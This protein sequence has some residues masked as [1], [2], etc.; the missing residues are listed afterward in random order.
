MTKKARLFVFLLF[1]I[2]F[3]LPVMVGAQ[4]LGHDIGQGLPNVCGDRVL[5]DQEECDDGNNVSGD[6]CSSDCRREFCG[7]GEVQEALEEECDDGNVFNGDTCTADCKKT[8]CG[9]G[10]VQNPNGFG[11]AEECDEESATCQS[12]IR[13]EVPQAC[14]NGD[15]EEFLLE[16][17]FSVL[18]P[19]LPTFLI[20]I[21]AYS[22]PVTIDDLDR[23]GCKEIYFLTFDE[24]EEAEIRGYYPSGSEVPGFPVPIG[25]ELSQAYAY[26]AVEMHLTVADT[27]GDSNKEIIATL[28]GASELVIINGVALP[29]R[30][31][32][33]FGNI[34]IVSHEG[35]LITEREVGRR[36]LVSACEFGGGSKDA[37]MYIEGNRELARVNLDKMNARGELIPFNNNYPLDIPVFERD[38]LDPRMSCA[39]IDGDGAKELLA[40]ITY[41]DQRLSNI[42]GGPFLANGAA[43]VAINF[44][45]GSMVWNEPR[46]L[47]DA[48]RPA[49]IADLLGG[50][51]IPELFYSFD[52]LDRERAQLSS[53]LCSDGNVCRG[54][55]GLSAREAT[56]FN[57]WPLIIPEDGNGFVFSASAD[58]AVGDVDGD[59]VGDIVHGGRAFG[60]G[61]NQIDF[62]INVA[63]ANGE[64]MAGNWPVRIVNVEAHSD[65]IWPFED[66]REAISFTTADINGDS[67]TEILALLP[68]GRLFAFNNLGNIIPGFPKEPSFVA[69]EFPNEVIVVGSSGV[70]VVDDLA[71]DGDIEIFTSVI[72]SREDPDL[73]TTNF[74]RQIR[75]YEMEDSDGRFAKWPTARGNNLRNGFYDERR[76]F[77]RR[78]IACDANHDG[79]AN[80]ADVTYLF[81]HL[82]FGSQ[83]P[84]CRPEADCNGDGG[85]NLADG[86][87]LLSHLFQQ[88]E[89]PPRIPLDA[90]C[91]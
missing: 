22:A 85:V 38:L 72:F 90:V 62:L 32:N 24:N 11:Q 69:P 88:G 37:L 2:S 41:P 33:Y 56:P 50:D 60:N 46:Y 52:R 26:P 59:G 57:D 91:E 64:Q 51:G 28:S 83:A 78:M 61:G 13:I 43:A 47:R 76:G 19:A 6:G 87:F 15:R 63:H 31:S 27:Y 68:D 82:F 42:N 4:N 20:D 71:S 53:L 39:D 18:R 80:I 54:V 36:V 7:D 48:Y 9:D 16:E 44:R 29:K 55:V 17:E 35:E 81:N 73:G 23:D 45:D 49:V 84:L 67:S 34:S 8:Y 79:I 21:R 75:S 3:C 14:L 70:A 65:F 25:R 86:I 10:R 30:E 40:S 1:C 12:C 58:I 74:Y 77:G 89:T 66:G 5:G